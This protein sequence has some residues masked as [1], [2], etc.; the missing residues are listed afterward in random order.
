MLK[1]YLTIIFIDIILFGLWDYWANSIHITQGESI[2]V[3]LVVPALI[4]LS[5]I[6][7]LILKFKKSVWGT[8]LLINVLISI[9]IFIGLFKYEFWKQQHD[10]YLT[11]YFT[12]NKTIY[13]VTLKLNNGQLQNGLT[14]NIYERLGEYG[15][16][17]TDLNGSYLKNNDTLLLTSDKGKVMKIFG[18]T[19]LGYSQK[20]DSITLRN[21]PD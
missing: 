9:I 21:H 16:G 15:N 2:G 11:Y 13:N 3:I 8:V 18:K 10:D 19:L 6:I 17:G 12:D 7:G 20:N 1:K 14:Y 4:I 5:G